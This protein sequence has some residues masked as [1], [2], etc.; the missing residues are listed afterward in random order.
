MRIVVTGVKG[1]VASSLL[2]RAKDRCDIVALGR[3]D[4]DLADRDSVFAR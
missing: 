3:P 4:L 1:Q 2:E